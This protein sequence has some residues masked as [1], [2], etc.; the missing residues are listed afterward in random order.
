MRKKS[1]HSSKERVKDMAELAVNKFSLKDFIRDNK[2][3]IEAI[4]PVNPAIKSGDEWENEDCWED[5][6]R[7]KSGK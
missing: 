6:Y 3:K 1:S 5:L 2:K 7:K 4:T